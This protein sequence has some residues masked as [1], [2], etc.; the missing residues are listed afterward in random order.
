MLAHT[1]SVGYCSLR[2]SETIKEEL[3]LIKPTSKNILK[4]FFG[5]NFLEKKLNARDEISLPLNF[6]NHNE[7]YPLYHGRYVEKIY[8][9]ENF[10]ILNKPE[11]I[12]MHPLSYLERNN[13]LS[14]I[15]ENYGDSYLQVNKDNYDRGFLFRLDFETSG[16]SCYAKNDSTYKTIR[17]EFQ[18]LAKE[19]EYR[20]IVHGKFPRSLEMNSKMEPS[21]VK[22]YRMKNSI[23]GK[24]AYARGELISFD[25]NKNVSLVRIF[26]KTGL[27]HQIRFQ[28]SEAGFPILGDPLYGKSDDKERLFL[29]AYKYSFHYDDNIYEFY[30]SMPELFKGLFNFDIGMDEKGNGFR[31]SKAC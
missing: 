1:K 22:G 20:A 24:E 9:D 5:K 18:N 21:G 16:V 19:K 28:L 10:L 12:H 2:A 6:I 8:E 7:V 17:K 31:I 23:E 11:N 25:E 13:L 14:F 29:H 27:R 30:A 3:S 15:R 4:K 26:L